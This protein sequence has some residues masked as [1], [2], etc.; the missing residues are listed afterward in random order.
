MLAIAHW[1]M[2]EEDEARTWFNK[3]VEP[4]KQNPPPDAELRQ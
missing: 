2:G 3:A 4:A 1:R